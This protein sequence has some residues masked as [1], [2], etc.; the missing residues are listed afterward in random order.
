RLA[1]VLD[2]AAP[3]PRPV[4]RR[5]WIDAIVAALEANDA[6]AALA[7]FGGADERTLAAWAA[8]RGTG[9]DTDARSYLGATVIDTFGARAAELAGFTGERAE[10][11]APGGTRT[12][13]VSQLVFGPAGSQLVAAPSLNPRALRVC[14]DPNNLPFSNAR[15]EGFENALAALLAR[16]LGAELQYTWWPE[17]RGFLR[18]TLQAHRCELV[19]GLPAGSE[20]VATSRPVYRSAYALVRGPRAPRL[21]SLD[22]P[23]LHALR[24]GVP[25]VG[26]DGANPPP[27]AALARRGLLHNLR[28]YSV[29]GDYG[30]DSPGA[31]LLEAVHDGE[32][33]VAVAWG[34]LAGYHAARL[35][36]PLTPLAEPEFAF[37]IA[38]AVRR[39][40]RA[41]LAELDRV[42]VARRPEI[43]ALLDRFHVPRL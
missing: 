29:Y 16:E 39:E 33:D 38:L 18:Q 27:V 5:D 4:Q 7:R 21:A 9:L 23:E 37:D 35:A 2:H 32:V 12:L 24:I 43:D 20:R 25:L 26:D 14:A 19:L 36:L 17:R 41:L 30:R 40:D 34:P 1:I 31:A 11:R 6:D 42:L 22:A 3:I 13:P 28:G 8:P 15:G 10:L